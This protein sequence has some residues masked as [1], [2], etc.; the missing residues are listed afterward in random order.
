MNGHEV[1]EMASVIGIADRQVVG[2]KA[3]SFRERHRNAALVVGAL[4]ALPIGGAQP[5]PQQGAML[6][7]SH[8]STNVQADKEEEEVFRMRAVLQWRRLHVDFLWRVPTKG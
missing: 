2:F 7:T 6:G 3:F 8:A 5:A 1:N 4:R